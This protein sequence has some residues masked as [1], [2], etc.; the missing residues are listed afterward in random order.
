[1]KI[2]C[3]GNASYDITYEVD[4]YPIENT[5]NRIDKQTTCGGGPAATAA[6]LLGKWGSDVS[7][8]GVVGADLYGRKIK[9]EFTSV[10]VDTTYL[11]INKDIATTL[12]FIIA[13]TTNGSRTILTHRAHDLLMKDIDISFKPDILL[14]DG[15]EY[16]QSEKILATYPDIISIIDAG[17]PKPEVISL[18]HKVTYL[19]CSKE[20]A[21]TVTDYKLDYDNPSTLT[22]LYQKMEAIFNNVIVITLEA[23]GCIYKKDNKIM[24]M[25]TI[26]V[27]TVDSTGAGDIFHGAFTYGISKKWDIEKVITV[28]TIAAGISVTRV[29]TRYA[30]PSKE[31]MKAYYHDFE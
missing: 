25:P 24:L 27:K 23:H 29:G 31:E 30:V 15:Q 2:L 10:N 20:F 21:E 17:R 9:D 4:K 13:N 22:T 16:V 19:V 18:A 14:I 3:M 11:E 28:A 12:S 6:F 5:K 1:M 8:A 7:F 26:S